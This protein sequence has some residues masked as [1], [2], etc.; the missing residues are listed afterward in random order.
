MIEDRSQYPERWEQRD[1]QACIEDRAASH[2][3][4]GRP[5]NV[6][7]SSIPLRTIQQT[8]GAFQLTEVALASAGALFYG[9]TRQ[10]EAP[11]ERGELAGAPGPFGGTYDGEGKTHHS[12]AVALCN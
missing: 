12:L 10:E 11:A 1:K 5:N 2:H 9:N 6:L 7:G 4:S 3:P 8:F